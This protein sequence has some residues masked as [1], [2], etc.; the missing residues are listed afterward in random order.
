[1]PESATLAPER[2][3][4]AIAS[5]DDREFRFTPADFRAIAF[6]LREEAGIF[7]PEGKATLVYA[8]L[9]KRLA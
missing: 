2:S 8:R 3:T 5:S 1:M 7:L 6:V 9:A 4:S